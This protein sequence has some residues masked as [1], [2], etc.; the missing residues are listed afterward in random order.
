MSPTRNTINPPMTHSNN[1]TSKRSGSFLNNRSHTGTVSLGVSLLVRKNMDGKIDSAE[2]T[3]QRKSTLNYSHG[4][5][6]ITICEV[7]RDFGADFLSEGYCRTW[8]LKRMHPAGAFCPRCRRALTGTTMNRFWEG[9]RV[10]CSFCR[11]KFTALTG[12]Y[13]TRTHMS[14]RQIVL[15]AVF[16]GY[17]MP[18]R[19]IAEKAGVNKGTVMNWKRKLQ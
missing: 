9:Q 6:R 1:S 3:G 14:Y 18:V 19:T 8:V 7:V 15:I 13:L 4:V 12:T 10:R 17:G 16:V 2:N 11:K 5:R